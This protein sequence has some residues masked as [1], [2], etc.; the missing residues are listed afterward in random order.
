MRRNPEQSRL[1]NPVRVARPPTERALSS[2]GAVVLVAAGSLLV[3]RGQAA[4]P[5]GPAALSPPRRRRRPRP[6][7]A[8]PRP[9]PRRPN[10]SPWLPPTSPTT[11]FPIRPGLRTATY[12]LELVGSATNGSLDH[13]VSHRFG[14]RCRVLRSRHPGHRDATVRGDR[15]RGLSDRMVSSTDPVGAAHPGAGMSPTIGFV[16][17][18][19][20][21]TGGFSCAP[22][23]NGLAVDLDANVSGTTA[24][25]F[26]VSCTVGAHHSAHRLCD[27]AAH[28]DTATLTSNDL[29]VPP[30]QPTATCPAPVAANV[31]AIAGLPLSPGQSTP[32]SPSW[33]RSTSRRP[34]VTSTA[35][36]SKAG[37]P[38]GCRAGQDRPTTITSGR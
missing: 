17:N 27:R 34:D 5:V 36:L 38:P 35:H 8:A 22:S 32:R 25:L 14:H 3:W 15:Q 26:G 19:G 33:P 23:Q 1:R 10:E 29:I 21:I 12:Q 37:A 11:A 16:A 2:V 24:P 18:P 9:G 30:V 7:A 28:R 6:L 4:G 31:D 20:T 13:R